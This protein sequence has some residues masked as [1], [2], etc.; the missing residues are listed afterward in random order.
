[1]QIHLTHIIFFV[2]NQQAARDFYAQLLKTT[3]DVDVPGMTE[4]L[5]SPG[6][7]LGLMPKKGIKKILGNSIPDFDSLYPVPCCELYLYIGNAEL[8]MQHAI[9]CGARILSPVLHRNW[10]DYAGYVAD[11]D[12]NIIAFAEKG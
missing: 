9:T 1:M 8:A 2:E 7:R 10:G 3:P 12:G 6:C 11:P 4:F 5:L